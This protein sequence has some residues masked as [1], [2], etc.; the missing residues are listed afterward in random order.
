MSARVATYN[1][2]LGTI[3]DDTPYTF[4]YFQRNLVGT[5]SGVTG[6]KP[7]P[8]GILRFQDVDLK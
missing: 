5:A 1:V 3:L 4:V 8:D 7:T 2:A 6:L